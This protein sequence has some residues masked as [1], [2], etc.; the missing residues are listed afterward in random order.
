[1]LCQ[2]RAVGLSWMQCM[3]QISPS[4]ESVRRDIGLVRELEVLEHLRLA[5]PEGFE[6]FHGIDWMSEHWAV[7]RY[8][9]YN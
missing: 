7:D 8:D 4:L 6:V 2:N 9:E 1:M 3:A 5:L